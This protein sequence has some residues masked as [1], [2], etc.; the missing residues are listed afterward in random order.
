MGQ[1]IQTSELADILADSDI[2]LGREPDYF[3]RQVRQMA[4]YG[5]LKP[6]GMNGSGKTAARLFNKSETY[7]AKII[8]ALIDIGCSV[9]VQK[10]AIEAINKWESEDITEILG[11]DHQYKSYHWN[12]LIDSTRNNEPKLPHYLL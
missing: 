3:A 1:L 12:D 2:G 8:S 5:L 4:Q 9:Y 7:K 10:I 6:S 11:T